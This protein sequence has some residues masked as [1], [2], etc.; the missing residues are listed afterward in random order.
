MASNKSPP[1]QNSK[2]NVTFVVSSKNSN[3]S[4]MFGCFI[5]KCV[6]ISPSSPKRYRM[7]LGSNRFFR[8]IFAARSGF[9]RESALTFFGQQ[10]HTRPKVPSPNGPWPT[11][12]YFW[13]N[14]LASSS[15]CSSSSNSCRNKFEQL[16]SRT[17]PSP[18]KPVVLPPR[19]PRPPETSSATAGVVAPDASTS[20]FVTSGARDS[21]SANPRVLK[22]DCDKA[23]E[24][25]RFITVP[26]ID[27]DGHRSRIVGSNMSAPSARSPPG[28]CSLSG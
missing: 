15:T 13:S 24:E 9:S 28:G 6:A 2:T 22:W 16:S 26:S 1:L 19:P 7:S 10:R 21:P 8:T 12:V 11:N 20:A 23:D 14:S 3:N 5:V 17:R 4:T 25:F 27:I 18:C